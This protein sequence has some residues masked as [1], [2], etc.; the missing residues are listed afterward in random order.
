M[1][2]N[3]TQPAKEVEGDKKGLWH[4]I[5]QRR[6]KGLPAKKPGDKGYP[7]TLN[8]EDTGP[9]TKARDV[10]AKDKSQ[11]SDMI[12]REREKDKLKHD[13]LL[14]RARRAVMLNK[15]RGVSND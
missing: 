2:E 14:D 11:A 10:I 7:K 9:I 3:S 4:N 8:I 5:H 6:K 15:N 1:K 13:K 12:A